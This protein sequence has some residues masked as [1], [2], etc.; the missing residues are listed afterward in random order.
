[1]GH[2]CEDLNKV[3][4]SSSTSAQKAVLSYGSCTIANSGFTNIAF[5]SFV[6]DTFPAT[7]RP[8]ILLGAPEVNVQYDQS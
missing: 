5:D 8:G 3:G 1:M 7:S 4:T 2:S 6:D